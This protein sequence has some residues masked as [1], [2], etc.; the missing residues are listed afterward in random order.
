MPAAP[1][2]TCLPR[3]EIA[4]Q[5]PLASPLWSCP[6]PSRAR[7]LG[8]T[9]AR[10][11]RPHHG[12]VCQRCR[13]ED[14]RRGLAGRRLYGPP[15][16]RHGSAADPQAGPEAPHR[17]GHAP[18]HARCA[19]GVAPI[20][21][22]VR[23]GLARVK[24][25]GRTRSGKAVGRPRRDLD[26]QAVAELRGQGRSWREI[27]V[28]LKVPTRTLHRAWQNLPP[29]RFSGLPPLGAAGCGGS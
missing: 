22:R 13:A 19:L 15:A 10:G 25:T 8:L 4:W 17:P 9:R 16:G 24:A 23:S 26:L 18:A 3:V 11:P 2:G 14:H 29:P 6:A 27:S 1:S 28:A 20:R 12:S 7:K 21:D 5:F